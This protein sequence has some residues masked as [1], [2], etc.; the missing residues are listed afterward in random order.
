M[1]GPVVALHGGA[2]VDPASDYRAVERHLRALAERIAARLG[3]GL[4]ALDAVCEAVRDMEESGLYVAGRGSGPNR[5]GIVECD[6]CVMDGATAR[7]GAVAAVRRVRHPVLAARAVLETT[8]HVLLVGEGADR[9]ALAAGLAPV[10]DPAGWYRPAVGV[11]RADP[12]APPRHGTVGAVALDLAGRLAAASSTGGLLGKLPGR[13]GDTPIPGAGTWADD[14]LAVSCTGVGEAFIL[15][16]GA[17]DVAARV[18]YG[19]QALAAAAEALLARVAALGGDGGL[20]A[21][22]RAG[23]VVMPFNTAGMKRAVA[24]PGRATMAAVF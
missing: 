2:G 5:D 8:P 10:P 1:T 23:T 13:V 16:G 12:G 11:P 15:A 17:G 21:L 6:A 18:R 22:D 7:A 9:F 3:D 24:G 4:P 14:R 19:G 20:I